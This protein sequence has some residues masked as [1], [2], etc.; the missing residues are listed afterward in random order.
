MSG[1]PLPRT[2]R[3]EDSWLTQAHSIPRPPDAWWL[4]DTSRVSDY[5]CITQKDTKP[6]QTCSEGYIF[7]VLFATVVFL[8]IWRVVT[9]RLQTSRLDTR[10]LGNET[11]Q[12]HLPYYSNTE[13]V[14]LQP[15]EQVWLGNCR[16]A[17]IARVYLLS[18]LPFSHHSSGSLRLGWVFCLSNLHTVFG[19]V[20]PL[21]ELIRNSFISF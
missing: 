15:S 5:N 12:C 8:C 7:L 17:W 20:L 10:L 6:S 19:S 3:S 1:S 9:R 21:C 2:G 14:Y 13:K 4:K 16:V 11:V 18:R